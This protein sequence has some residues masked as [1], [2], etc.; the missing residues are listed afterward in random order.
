MQHGERFNAI[1]H[2]V[3]TIL[4][5]AGLVVLVVVSSLHRDPWRIVSVSIYGVSLV[6]LYTSSTLYHSASG[7]AKRVFRHFDHTAIY[8]LIA[9]SYTPLTLVSLRGR[10]GWWMFGTVW[11]LAAI[12]ALQ[13]FRKV[14]GERILSVVIYVVMGWLAMVAIK[15]LAVALG[16]GGLAWLMAGG[17]FYTG[18]IAFYALDHKLPV[19]HGIWHLFVLA[20]SLAHF[21]VI[22]DRVA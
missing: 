6:V 20:G 4:A 16:P 8:L 3:G 10:L 14:K 2:L 7:R 11:A 12:G 21:V 9:G 22:L 13:E 1:T 17:V 15:P 5:V 18:G 19:F